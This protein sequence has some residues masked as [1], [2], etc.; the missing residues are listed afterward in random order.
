MTAL[1]KPNRIVIGQSV[2]EILDNQQKSNF[3]A[4]SISPDAWSYLSNNT[5]IISWLYSNL[6]GEIR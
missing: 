4:L 3:E 5:G 2:Y 1:A 6:E